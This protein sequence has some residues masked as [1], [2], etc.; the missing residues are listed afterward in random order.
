MRIH[1]VPTY[2]CNLNCDFCY[3]AGLINDFRK[4]MSL[5]LFMD[6]FNYYKLHGMKSI[7]FLG[8]EPTV[9]PHLDYATNYARGNGLETIIFS[10]GSFVKAVPHL[11][12]LNITRFLSEPFSPALLDNIKWYRDNGVQLNFRINLTK[13]VSDNYLDIVL[14]TARAADADLQFAAIDCTPGEREFG[15]KI[16]IWLHRFVTSSFKVRISRPL[17]NCVFSPGQLDFI[18]EN[19]DCYPWCDFNNTVPVIN[20]DGKTVFPCNSLTIPLPLNYVWSK[21]DNFR[22][23]KLIQSCFDRIV[24]A[25]CVDCNEYKNGKCHGG[26]LSQGIKKLKIPG[27]GRKLKI[28]ENAE[29]TV[30]PKRHYV[31]DWG[32]AAKVIVKSINYGSL[33]VSGYIKL[34]Y[35]CNNHCDFCTVEWEKGLGNRKYEVIIKEID[36]LLADRSISVMHYSGGEPTLRKELPQILSYVGCRGVG[37]QIIQTN[38]RTI[39]DTDL[40]KK[41]VDSGATSFY[42]SI[43]GAD[44]AQHD[45]HVNAE[46]AFEQTC[47]GLDNLERYGVKFS[48]NTVITKSNHRS[49]SAIIQMIA[50]RYPSVTKA[51]LSYPNIQGGAADNFSKVVVPLGDCIM[52][53]KS[54]IYAGMSRNVFVDTE[55][56]PVC[57]LGELSDHA[58]EF[59]QNT[60]N[61]SDLH[62][63]K[64]GWNINERASGF[65]FYEGCSE[66][67]V[68]NICCGIH[69]FH[70]R[71]FEYR[72]IFYPVSFNQIGKSVFDVNQ[73]L[74]D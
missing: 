29:N 53:I 60:Y 66:C 2:A 28:P 18:N 24:P 51:K 62:Y 44:P 16:Y 13:T 72:D 26:C 39:A 1:I 38:G 68:R 74:Q 42:V 30:K 71:E 31:W 61:I 64:D 19:C 67:D 37:Q 43:H 14:D 59:I 23:I 56:V 50:G 55:S 49:L 70:D 36:N 45:S 57:L 58:C 41:L 63:R 40:L 20:P 47:K 27:P 33:P 35:K 9:W 12:V 73:L 3:A 54:A 25:E 15:Q 4:P 46:A 10:N 32:L 6:I 34:G 7:S 52:D 17:L 11:A 48:T 21:R 65:V 5:E 69:P 8:G 22:E